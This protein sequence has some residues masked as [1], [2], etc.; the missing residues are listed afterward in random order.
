MSRVLLLY[1][2]RDSRGVKAH[3]TALDALPSALVSVSLTA[4]EDT[5]EAREARQ[6]YREYD[7]CSPAR[8]SG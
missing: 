5:E 1:A 3:H 8:S 2:K 6:Q 7:V 4:A